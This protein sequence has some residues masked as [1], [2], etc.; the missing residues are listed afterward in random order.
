MVT[1]A[2]CESSCKA[3]SCPKDLCE[4]RPTP[5]D[6]CH[7]PP[8]PLMQN[9]SLELLDILIDRFADNGILVL[10]DL[11][12]L[13]PALEINGFIYRGG[14]DASRLFF[15]ETHPASDAL[16]GWAKLAK[17]FANRWNVLGIDVFNEP[18]DGTWAEGGASDMDAF[19]REVATV[20]HKQ[21]PNW[22]VFVQ[23]TANSPEPVAIIDGDKV[24]TGL[25]DN[26]MGAMARPLELAARE[27][28]VYSPHAYGPAAHAARKEFAHPTF[29]ANMPDVWDAHWGSLAKQGAH[30]QGTPAVVLGEWGTSLVGDDAKW[31]EELATYLK[32]KNLTS[33]FFWALNPAGEEGS[34]LIKVMTGRGA[35]GKGRPSVDEA[36]LDL[37]RRVTPHPTDILEVYRAARAD[38]GPSPSPSPAAS[39]AASPEARRQRTRTR[40][41]KQKAAKADGKLAPAEQEEKEKSAPRGELLHGKSCPGHPNILRTS[42]TPCPPPARLAR[43]SGGKGVDSGAKGVDSDGGKGVDSGGEATR[44]GS[45]G[46]KRTSSGA[47]GTG[48]QAV[49]SAYDPARE[50]DGGEVAWTGA[51]LDVAWTGAGGGRDVGGVVAADIRARNQRLVDLPKY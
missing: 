4:K 23:G 9:T 29:P 37:L 34:G 43:D 33:T 8:S 18:A 39:P 45:G 31:A 41:P 28:L 11:H 49:L 35:T 42:T 6:I 10:L 32:A 30:A 13:A 25:G 21:A 24:R 14:T 19:A 5:A 36:K 50:G 1:D 20:V 16:K 7:T 46:G 27:K 47:G 17:R 15:D 26:L 2:W 22:L 51:H 40:A 3:G 12:C 44:R 38:A 48:G